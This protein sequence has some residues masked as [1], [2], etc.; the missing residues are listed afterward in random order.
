MLS[1]MTLDEVKLYFETLSK[2]TPDTLDYW[3]DKFWSDFSKEEVVL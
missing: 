1:T 2:V 3:V